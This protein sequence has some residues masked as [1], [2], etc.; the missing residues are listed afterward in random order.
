MTN[1]VRTGSDI[2]ADAN[3]HIQNRDGHGNGNGS[4]AGKSK[5]NNHSKHANNHSNNHSNNN[6]NN[7]S[8]HNNS[9]SHNSHNG[10]TAHNSHHSLLSGAN[11]SLTDYV[12]SRWYRAPELM[13]QSKVYDCNVDIWALGCTMAEF[14]KNSPMFTGVYCGIIIKILCI[15]LLYI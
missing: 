10:S 2:V 7:H 1:E 12:G 4:V 5:H 13:G 15:L 9:N 14:A 3:E 11:D 8:D 6:S